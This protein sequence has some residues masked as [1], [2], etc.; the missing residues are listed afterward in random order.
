MSNR[1]GNLGRRAALTESTIQRFFGS[2]SL[3]F[4]AFARH[5]MIVAPPTPTEDVSGD[6]PHTTSSTVVT[7]SA[8]RC[9]RCRRTSLE[10]P[11]APMKESF[12]RGAFEV[13]AGTDLAPDDTDRDYDGD[14]ASALGELG[15]DDKRRDTPAWENGDDDP[16]SQ[17]PLIPLPK[18][19]FWQ[20]N[21]EPPPFSAH[22]TTL[23]INTQFGTAICVFEEKFNM[24]ITCSFPVSRHMEGVS[25]ETP[26][27]MRF[28]SSLSSEDVL[29][30]NMEADPGL[31]VCFGT[32]K[33]A[34]RVETQEVGQNGE[35]IVTK[36]ILPVTY[37]E[38]LY[39]I[40]KTI[41]S[42][43]IPAAGAVEYF[44]EVVRQLYLEKLE[45]QEKEVD[46]GIEIKI[47][48]QEV[49]ERARLV[50]S[51][52]GHVISPHQVVFTR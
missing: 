13:F 48:E 23:V 43:L 29:I 24:D 36:H 18:G 21:L 44:A 8:S 50:A 19:G 7:S 16:T 51:G 9:K 34:E 10:P 12:P 47:T 15:L 41:T 3:E 2:G 1:N 35:P 20:K 4:E 42:S 39:F 40:F 30:R 22:K 52:S 6:K 28:H 38:S 11:P 25:K 37:D 32:G 45:A 14:L 26:S 5:S 17:A 46:S 33:Y 49:F 27:N 31:Q